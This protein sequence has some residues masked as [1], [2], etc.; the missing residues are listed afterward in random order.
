MTQTVVIETIISERPQGGAI[1]SASTLSG[2]K[3]H[4]FIANAEV[5]PRAPVVGEVWDIGGTVKTHPEYGP[6]VEAATAA[7]RRP[8]G[9]LIVNTL[10]KS[11]TFKGI[12]DAR[13]EKLWSEFGEDLY[14]ML[15]AC[16]P[17]DES[18]ADPFKETLGDELAQVLV[19][20]WLDL[21]VE[22]D[23]YRWLDAHA[24][25]VRIA[26]KIINIYG[27]D[28][29]EK[30][31][32]NPY[33]LLAFLP[34]KQTD[35]IGN[36]LG[37]P[38]DDER[39][40]IA[41]ADAA[42]YHRI[43]LSHTVTDEQEFISLIQGFLG[44]DQATAKKALWSAVENSAVVFLGSA[45]QGL[46]PASMERFI[47]ERAALMM[48]SEFKAT[49]PTIRHAPDDA[50]LEAIFSDFEASEGIALNQAQR[51]AVAMA[52][53]SSISV[54]TGGAGVG[55][56]TALKA[57]HTA[58]QRCAAPLIQMAL[59]GR[60]AKRMIE[61]TSQPAMTI[62]KFLNDVDRE[63]ITLDS[64]QMIVIDESSML[65]LPTMYRIM[66]RM[67]PGCRL[68]LVGDPSQLP[69]I[70]F[71][72][73]FHSFCED[74]S[75]PLVELTEVHRQ[76]ASTGIPQASIAVRNGEVP[77]LDDYQGKGPGVAFIDADKDQI[78][79][80]I[81]DVVSD[82]GDDESQII[83]AVKG[84]AAGTQTI[85]KYF[86][87]L[88][89][90]GRPESGGFAE[91]EPVIWTVNNYDLDLMNG[92]LGKV[93][94]ADDPDALVIDFDGDLKLIPFTDLRDMEHSYA[95]TTHKSQGSQF[96]RVIIPVFRNKLLDRTL[97]YTAIT[98]AQEQVVLVGD[99]KAFEAAVVADPNP[100]RRQVGLH[101]HMQ[102]CLPGEGRG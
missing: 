64:E 17:D 8:T 82:F 55:K 12:G 99:R 70:G 3:K 67:E 19:D 30:L 89:T 56:T 57:I 75:L 88:L 54:L 42:V 38:W 28:A 96:S 94:S 81:Q 62:Q 34:W 13:A 39:R 36:A 53:S 85:N 21:A 18:R 15:D 90:P 78:V 60:A 20:G 93:I 73:V 1:F 10:A 27:N 92:S 5:M 35:V 37:V 50:Q 83:G 65:D 41:A 23:V 22:A 14:T 29:V 66:R 72:L 102:T 2:G 31:G 16:R 68:L 61:A 52:T 71:G 45:L 74:G 48:R 49:N 44:S 32:D 46:G 98:R 80:I 9:R 76:A 101:E 11:K 87:D 43:D 4:R 24:V 59:A 79:D 95:I 77:D 100:S 40:L 84:G 86:H 51:D 7:P 25:P 47:A 6:Q 63:K 91:G 26:R 33:R 97:L 58:S 69:P